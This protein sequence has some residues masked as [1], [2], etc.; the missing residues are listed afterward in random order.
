MKSLL[1]IVLAC[2]FILWFQVKL[3]LHTTLWNV[4]PLRYSVMATND[5]SVWTASVSFLQNKNTWTICQ[6]HQHYCVKLSDIYN[7]LNWNKWVGGSTATWLDAVGLDVDQ[8]ATNLR[9]SLFFN[10]TALR[11]KKRCEPKN[12][13]IQLTHWGS[14]FFHVT[15]RSQP[16]C[17]GTHLVQ[18]KKRSLFCHHSE[19]RKLDLTKCNNIKLI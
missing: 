9:I 4:H 8:G 16:L 13:P 5:S 17:P 12:C 15:T 19:E 18:Q 7:R 2:I 14:L 10:L 3:K 6:I 1:F 11:G